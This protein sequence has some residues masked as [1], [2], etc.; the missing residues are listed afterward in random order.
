MKKKLTKISSLILAAAMTVSVLAGCGNG[1][2]SETAEPAATTAE[3]TQEGTAEAIEAEG[4]FEGTAKLVIDYAQAVDPNGE[5]I[6]NGAFQATPEER[7]GSGDTDDRN[8]KSVCGNEHRFFTA[9][10]C[11]IGMV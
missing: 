2:G 1:A 5:D 3:E 8:R 4:A 11:G 10:D 7:G 9:Q 6:V